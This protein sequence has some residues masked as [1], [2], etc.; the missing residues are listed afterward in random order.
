MAGLC[1]G[2]GVNL[3]EQGERSLRLGVAAKGT[4]E[5]DRRGRNPQRCAEKSGWEE[6]FVHETQKCLS[7]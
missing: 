2:E 6:F 5:K 1:V 7:A 3:T 4:A